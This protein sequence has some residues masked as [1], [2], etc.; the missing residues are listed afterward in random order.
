MTAA[1]GIAAEAVLRISPDDEPRGLIGTAFL[2]AP[3]LALTCAH[4]LDGL[5]GRKLRLSGRCGEVLSCGPAHLPP[6]PGA[7]DLALLQVEPDLRPL[8]PCV[9]AEQPPHQIKAQGY[10]PAVTSAGGRELRFES[11]SQFTA[12]YPGQTRTYRIEDAFDLAGDPAE[13]GFSGSPLIDDES[14][15]A[16]AVLSG[17]DRGRLRSW[18]VPLRAAAEVWP[19][20]AAAL[21][22]NDE[23]LPRF[24]VHANRAGALL[25]CATQV[26]HALRR[27]EVIKKFDPSLNV[28][29]KAI[30]EPLKQFRSSPETAM[31]IVGE[32]NVGKTWLLCSLVGSDANAPMLLLAAADLPSDNPPSLP[33]LLEQSLAAAWETAAHAA[34]PPSAARLARALRGDPTALT[35]ALD[36]VNEALHVRHFLS[37]WLPEALGWCREVGAK[38]LLTTRPEPWPAVARSFAGSDVLFAWPRPEPRQ[39]LSAEQRRFGLADFDDEEATEAERAYQLDPAVAEAL[40]G[41]PLLYRAAA[42]LGLS[43]AGSHVGRY[44]LLDD[45]ARRQVDDAA[46]AIG[47]RPSGTAFAKIRRLAGE[48]P[49]DGGPALPVG[50]ALAILGGDDW[51]GALID[52]GLLSY[53]GEVVR[54]TYDQIAEAMR[55]APDPTLLFAR[56]TLEQPELFRQSIVGLL[57]LE[58]DGNERLFAAGLERMEVLLADGKPIAWG[59][60]LVGLSY[61]NRSL[62]T[63]RERVVEAVLNLAMRRVDAINRAESRN[64]LLTLIEE[65]PLDATRRCHALLGVAP[66]EE[67][68][69][70]R[71]KDW[72]DENRRWTFVSEIA[73]S[74]PPNAGSALDR[75]H[76]AHLDIVRPILIEALADQT[77]FDRGS[78]M[79]SSSEAS[80]AS[81]AAGLLFHRRESDL[82][83]LLELLSRKRSEAGARLARALAAEM[84]ERLFA[85]ATRLLEQGDT[86]VAVLVALETAAEKMD[87]AIRRTAIPL[88]E[89]LLAADSTISQSAAVALRGV[90]DTH[91]GA[92]DRLIEAQTVEGLSSGYAMSPTPTARFNRAME[93]A[94]AFPKAGLEWMS[95]HEGDEAQQQA[96]ALLAEKLFARQAARPFLFGRLVEDKL[97]ALCREGGG[98]F[99]PWLS[100]AGQI[101][102]STDK[103]ARECVAYAV[104]R[105]HALIDRDIAALADEFYSAVLK[106]DVPSVVDGLMKFVAKDAVRWRAHFVHIRSIDREAADRQAFNAVGS[107][108]NPPVE[109]EI[110]LAFWQELPVEQRSVLARRVLDMLQTSPIDAVFSRKWWEVVE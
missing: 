62:P 89:R 5:E 56:E 15:C 47:A 67:A 52:A 51:L 3:G 1:G 66:W 50:R 80:I 7:V 43:A 32:S 35:V 33:V 44:R 97:Y 9:P 31:A 83:G 63:G 10:C 59:I 106:E 75:L 57:R 18:A 16:F 86:S 103:S 21:V 28:A 96:M 109:R 77:P 105:E 84:P 17:G 93:L 94:A 101:A 73:R 12:V 8:L 104:F 36:G 13:P 45:F 92:W 99:R 81:F 65:L 40:R 53:S 37:R 108:N 29:R 48:L 91:V 110:L 25:T 27:M 87:K 54:F 20:L 68:Y 24:G 88:L 39:R 38:L 46:Q 90:D 2:V 58:A 64:W 42:E 26:R 49:A 98:Q 82:G 70:F 72:E 11:R 61:L 71:F 69:P 95:V 41:H 34:L 60:V 79:I 19:E 6:D 22:W 78:D 4:V 74:M 23:H 102:R 107:F 55:P 30:A 76:V 100:L 14:G 85:E